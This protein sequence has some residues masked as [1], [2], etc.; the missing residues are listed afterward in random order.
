MRMGNKKVTLFLILLIFII[1]CEQNNLNIPSGIV[2]TPLTGQPEANSS[3]AKGADVKEEAITSKESPKAAG[4]CDG[5]CDS[6]EEEQKEKS[7]CYKPDCLGLKEQMQQPQQ[8]QE[9]D[10]ADKLQQEQQKNIISVSAISSQYKTTTTKP[11]GWFKTGQDADIMLSGID[12]N[13]AGSSLLFNHPGNLATDGKR[14]ALADRNNNRIL[15]WNSLP[16]SNEQPDLVIGQKDFTSNNPGSALDKLNWPVGVALSNNKLVVADTYNHR[17]LVWDSFPSSN[18]QA[19]DFELNEEQSWPWAVWTDSNKLV[20]AHTGKARI[21]I[22][23]T[24]P[25]A[26]KKPDITIESRGEIGTPRSIGSDGKSLVIGDH[27]AFGNKQGT[28]FWKNFPASNN[29]KYD[30]FVSEIK[31][32]GKNSEPLLGSQMW[33]SIVAGDRKLIGIASMLHIWDSFPENENNNPDLQVGKVNAGAPGYDFGGSQ[34]GDGSGIALA[35]DKL[36]VSLTNGNK[37]VGY[38]SIPASP[39]QEP[40]FAIGANSIYENTLR[41]NYFATNAIIRTNGDSLFVVSTFDP[42]MLVWKKIP[43]ESGTAPDYAYELGFSPVEAAIIDNSLI[44]SDGKKFYIWNSLP[45]N[46]EMPDKI[47][48]GI[49]GLKLE[50]IAGIAKDKKYYYISDVSSKKVYVFDDNPFAKSAPVKFTANIDAGKLSSDGKYLVTIAGNQ[51][52]RIYQVS[53]LQS[54][55]PGLEIPGR[56]FNLPMSVIINDG[57]LFVADTVFNRVQIWNSVESALSGKEPDVV[58]GQKNMQD[59]GPSIGKNRLFWPSELE[60]NDGYLWVGEYKFSGRV[61]RFSGG[62]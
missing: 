27:N 51:M 56:R 47:T 48:E 28:F 62:K 11:T 31:N 29:Q 16:S 45:L 8:I 36:Y 35:G 6:F 41:E 19:A 22:W 54:S 33:Q 1:G 57:R 55:P 37:I 7:P 14:L 13:N 12:F 23:N 18:G 10:I 15:I 25:S 20:V 53:E 24:F 3:E 58:L 30:F 4:G 9:I 50:K 17:I 43:D 38:N 32:M 59:T 40:D 60:F 26:N 42:R 49:A 52:P 61:L 46:G 39:L 21:S 34:S 44:L 2:S 5:I